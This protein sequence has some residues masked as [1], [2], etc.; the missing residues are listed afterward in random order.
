MKLVLEITSHAGDGS[1][2][3]RSV[4]TFPATL[5][6]GYH[7]DIIINDPHVSAQHL[8]IDFDGQQFSI[9]DLGSENGLSVNEQLHKSAGATLKSGDTVRAGRTIIR[10]FDPAHPVPPAQRLQRA[11]PFLL[12]L[13]RP[14]TVWAAFALA[15]AITV[16]REYF[17][18]FQFDAAMDMGSVALVCAI[19]II[20]WSALWGVAGKLVRHKSRFRSHVALM[21]LFI[22][23]VALLDTAQAYVDFLGTG[24]TFADLFMNASNAC[25]ALAL[26]YGSLTLATDMSQKKRRLWVGFFAAG[27]ILIGVATSAIDRGN[28]NPSP[29]FSDGLE[30]YLSQLASADSVGGFMQ[31]NAALFDSDTFKITPIL[32]E[33]S[34]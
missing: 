31:G 8:R 16:A 1:I 12:W 11:N 5:G 29:V 32:S 10:V 34:K 26:L 6:R 19:V 30:P 4:E 2:A 15:L 18:S 28:F 14:V 33:K 3:H 21:S 25:L 27:A 17:S 23:A 24:K 9:H 13:A 7:N 20:L 22:V